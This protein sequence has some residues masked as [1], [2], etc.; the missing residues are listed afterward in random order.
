MSD[1]TAHVPPDDVPSRSRQ[2]RE[3][4]DVLRLA[5]TLAALSPTERESIP[6]PDLLADEVKRAAAVGSHIARKRQVQYLAKQLRNHPDAIEAIR[7]ALEHDRRR[8]RSDAARQQRIEDW[9][10]RLVA[11][12]KAALGEL[13]AIHPGA[14]RQ[15][16]HALARQAR[17]ERERNGSP[18]A[19]RELF[20]LL[21]DLF[22]TS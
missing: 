19:Y 1:A 21:R 18:R 20:H 2:R 8:A 22:E 10:E 14:D 6:L 13:L 11:D 3:A 16:I 7:N 9:R 5:Q 17:T 15:R 12:D 4:L